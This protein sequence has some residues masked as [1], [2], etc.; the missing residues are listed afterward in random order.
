MYTY[1]CQFVHWREKGRGKKTAANT[2][3]YVLHTSKICFPPPIFLWFFMEEKKGKKER[4]YRGKITNSP[5]PTFSIAF[6][7]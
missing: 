5:F 6:N 7:R 2:C 4:K 3:M 1:K